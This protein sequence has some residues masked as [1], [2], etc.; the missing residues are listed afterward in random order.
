MFKVPLFHTRWD[1][2][3]LKI[4]SIVSSPSSYPSRCILFSSSRRASVILLVLTKSGVSRWSASA[5]SPL[6]IL[7]ESSQTLSKVN[8]SC[9]I[10]SS[11]LRLSLREESDSIQNRFR[12]ERVPNFKKTVCYFKSSLF[13]TYLAQKVVF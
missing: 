9:N 10:N 8:P 5:F 2:L 11:V 6:S 13:P 12:V 3:H 4:L 1:V 7:V